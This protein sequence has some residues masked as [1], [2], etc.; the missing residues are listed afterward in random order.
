MSLRKELRQTNSLLSLAKEEAEIAR[1]E[2]DT[3]ALDFKQE[4]QRAEQLKKLLEA[5]GIPIPE[6]NKGE[7]GKYLDFFFVG[8]LFISYLLLFMIISSYYHCLK[9]SNHFPLVCSI[10]NWRR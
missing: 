7:G 8:M 5:N 3:L 1:K 4:T 10:C 6:V 2:K 9:E